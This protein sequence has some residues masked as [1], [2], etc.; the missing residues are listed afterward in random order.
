MDDSSHQPE[1]SPA[2]QRQVV[3]DDLTC[4]DCGHAL[5]GLRLS[6][7]CSNCELPVIWSVRHA[8]LGYVDEPG[9]RRNAERELKRDLSC[10]SCGYNLRGLSRENDCPECGTAV[11]WSVGGFMLDY[12]DPDWL[13]KLLRGSSLLMFS[14]YTLFMIGALLVVIAIWFDGESI[15]PPSR[16]SMTA[17]M[18]MWVDLVLVIY[19]AGTWKLTAVEPR[20]QT[21]RSA[22]SIRMLARA[23]SLVNVIALMIVLSIRGIEGQRIPEWAW[24]VTLIGAVVSHLLFIEYVIKLAKRMRSQ[25]HRRYM[26]TYQIAFGFMSIV[27]LWMVTPNTSAGVDDSGCCGVAFL[28]GSTFPFCI[29]FLS[30]AFDLN[31]T[32]KSAL[33]TCKEDD[34]R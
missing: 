16:L 22:L 30:V 24:I 4:R 21:N 28:F 13:K 6:D 11:R 8:G 3:A 33:L 5:A 14:V 18:A 26:R 9:K 12:A 2:D 15:S 19:V 17:L 31:E 1:S 10:R 23:T 27:A 29:W 25:I 32:L 7:E 20:E 34:G